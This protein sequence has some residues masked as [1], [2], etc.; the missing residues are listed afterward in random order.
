[1]TGLCVVTSVRLRQ[2]PQSSCP[3]ASS[4]K[5]AVRIRL[6]APRPAPSILVQSARDETRARA[7][8]SAL[9]DD[10]HGAMDLRRAEERGRIAA[11]ARR[12][13]EEVPERV[14]GPGFELRCGDFREVLADVEP[15]SVDAIVCDPPYDDAGVPLYSDLSAFA[16]RVLPPWPA[17]C[18][19]LRA[20][21]PP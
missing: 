16:A 1:M 4:A 18:R 2:M 12:R 17:L 3:S 20:H 5:A 11:L 19:L 9:G 21:G 10:A 13:T 6:V 14:E 7:A 8:L 15:G